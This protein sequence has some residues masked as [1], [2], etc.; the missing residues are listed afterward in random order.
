MITKIKIKTLKIA[1]GRHLGKIN[2]WKGGL[3]TPHRKGILSLS[4]DV[5]F[6]KIG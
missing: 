5:S 4:N 2:K 3:A 6:S 1:V